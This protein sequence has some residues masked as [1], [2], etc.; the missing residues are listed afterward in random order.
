MVRRL[1]AKD[2]E[3]II[4]HEPEE[5][6]IE[7]NASAIDEDTDKEVVEWIRDQLSRGNTWAWCRVKVSAAWNGFIGS[8]Y[9]GCCSY[10]SEKD[11]KACGYYVDMKV[12]ALAALNRE[13]AETSDTLALLEEAD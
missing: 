13:I 6:P 10:K 9:L 3:F 11:F 4:E 12:E 5:T 2:V 7:G 8:D 1:T